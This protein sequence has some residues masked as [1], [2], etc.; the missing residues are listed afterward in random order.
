MMLIPDYLTTNQSEEWPEADHAPCSI[1]PRPVS[2]FLKTCPW[3]SL[4]SVGLLSISC[5]DPLLGA[6]Q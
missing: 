4:E 6:L 2:V 1:L 5:Q 3:K